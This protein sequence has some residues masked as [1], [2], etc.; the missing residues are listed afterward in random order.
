[1][2]VQFNIDTESKKDVESLLKQAITL[3][4]GDKEVKPSVD[5]AMTETIIRILEGN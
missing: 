5:K 4:R 3:Y 1:M 2:K